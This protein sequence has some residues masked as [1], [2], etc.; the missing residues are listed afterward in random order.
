M[1]TC[2]AVC[3]ASN[4]HYGCVL[5]G[6][7]QCT[8]LRDW[9]RQ[10]FTNKMSMWHHNTGQGR[11]ENCVCLISSYV[12]SVRTGWA[13]LSGLGRQE[14]WAGLPEWAAQHGCM[15]AQDSLTVFTAVGGF[16]W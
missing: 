8:R 1:E 11:M 5:T 14:G 10:A 7:C 16:G 2:V 6:Y 12:R 9:A 3:R 4:G 13:G 15:A